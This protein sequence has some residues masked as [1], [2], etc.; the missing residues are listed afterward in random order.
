MALAAT[1]N[2]ISAAIEKL[3]IK[4]EIRLLQIISEDINKKVNLQNPDNRYWLAMGENSFDRIWDN[5]E[6]EVY[7]ELL[8]R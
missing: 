5:Q 8:Q 1:I 2:D 6:D 7:S 3:E 4:E